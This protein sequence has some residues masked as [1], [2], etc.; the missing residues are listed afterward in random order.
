M[1]HRRE[2]KRLEQRR[3][4]GVLEHLMTTFAITVVVVVAVV[5]AVP[6]R[7]T[8]SIEYLEV[9]DDTLYYQVRLDDPEGRLV[10]G[11]LIL[12]LEHPLDRRE[13]SLDSGV[14]S[15]VVEAL[16]PG[17][18]YKV[19]LHASQGYGEE[20]LYRATIDTAAQVEGIIAG[21]FFQENVSSG[22]WLIEAILLTADVTEYTNMTAEI[23]WWDPSGFSDQVTTSLMTGFNQVLL[24]QVSLWFT[25]M[26][27]VRLLGHHPTEGVIELDVWDSIMP[28]AV[29]ASFYLDE[30]GMDTMLFAIYPDEA[31]PDAVYTL[32]LYQNAALIEHSTVSF[33]VIEAPYRMGTHRIRNLKPNT[34]YTVELWVSYTDPQTGLS[35]SRA[36]V[37][38]TYQTLAWHQ[39]DVRLKA[40]GSAF[41]VHVMTRD[42]DQ[43]LRNLRVYLYEASEPQHL[44]RGSF[45]PDVTDLLPDG[46]VE[47]VFYI[48]TYA[49]ETLI[50]DVI[51]DYA[52]AGI[53]TYYHHTIDSQR[54]R[55]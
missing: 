42:P 43:V 51:A 22:Y 38:E 26:I 45:S 33:S 17:S 55:D 25:G 50:F 28:H 39:V 36:I 2:D 29:N 40:E 3:R 10:S 53:I 15:G 48:E 11:S 31:L 21:V 16:R 6:A 1:R 47:Y 24:E 32:Y 5:L 41:A 23:T 20:I 44:F 8:G 14:H 52:V 34:R 18:R 54:I 37:K 7:L 9:V 46:R 35:K 4:L 12:R 27:R 30:I 13:I 49:A 19:T